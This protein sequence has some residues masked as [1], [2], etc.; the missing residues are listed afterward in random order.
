MLSFRS[1]FF[2]SI[3][4]VDIS[5]PIVFL[6]NY[7]NLCFLCINVVFHHCIWYITLCILLFMQHYFMNLS[8]SCQTSQGIKCS[9]LLDIIE[10]LG[11]ISQF[12]VLSNPTLTL[13]FQTRAIYLNLEYYQIDVSGHLI[14]FSDKTKDIC[15]S[16]L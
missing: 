5:H 1:S 6:G 12:S 8:L 4:K 11:C 9:Y 2:F 3:F 13:Q 15:F 16:F 10:Y 14:F 7:N